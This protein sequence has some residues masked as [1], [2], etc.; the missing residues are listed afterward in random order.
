MNS[1]SDKEVEI[2]INDYFSMLF[3]E[4]RGIKI[5]KAQHRKNLLPLLNRRTDGSIE[6]KHQNISAVL[7]NIGRPSIN[8]YLPLYNYQKKLEDKVIEYLIN[9]PEVEELCRE[10]ADKEVIR[11][12]PTIDFTRLIVTPPNPHKIIE[13]D[14]LNQ[15]IPI[16]VNYLEREQLN[17][18]LGIQ[19]EKL[20]LEYEKWHL[21]HEGLDKLAE[22]VRWVSQEEGDSAGFDILSKKS[23]GKDKYIEVKTTKLSKEAP[24]FFT[25]NELHFSIKNQEKYFLYRLFDFEERPRMF[26]KN[27]DLDSMCKSYPVTYKAYF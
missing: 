19:G 2:I 27:G 9:H 18:K 26:I 21:Q 6:F 13:S 11:T 15:R 22:E 5:N 20:V 24:F 4:K 23:N 12:N 16:K 3:D 1:W 14:Y 10:F 7:F 8:G 17:S 25:R